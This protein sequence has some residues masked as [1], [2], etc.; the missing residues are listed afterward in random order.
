[1][2]FRTGISIGNAAIVGTDAGGLC[3][4]AASTTQVRVDLAGW[5]PPVT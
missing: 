1:V 4:Y 5:F 2:N 3:I